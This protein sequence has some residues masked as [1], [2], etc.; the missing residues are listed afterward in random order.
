MKHRNPEVEDRINTKN[1]NMILKI[2]VRN[3]IT[4]RSSFTCS[5]LREEIKIRR[6]SVRG[7]YVG[8]SIEDYRILVDE[9]W[10]DLQAKSTQN[11]KEI[12]ESQFSVS[13]L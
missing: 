1:Q 9:A 6:P 8:S 4:E 11:C 13:R 12:K 10:N 3:R 5:S 2:E 7:M